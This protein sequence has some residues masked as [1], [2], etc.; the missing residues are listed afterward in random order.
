[1]RQTEYNELKSEIHRYLDNH[2]V[3]LVNN[4]FSFYARKVV[5]ILCDLRDAMFLGMREETRMYFNRLC[6]EME[7]RRVS[8]KKRKENSQLKQHAI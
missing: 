1:M 7:V 6:N 8:E 2:I 4:D 5:P 3:P